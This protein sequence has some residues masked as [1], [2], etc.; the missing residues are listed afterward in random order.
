MLSDVPSS[1]VCRFALVLAVVC[2]ECAPVK[3]VMLV[4]TVKRALQQR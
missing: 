2:V 4:P 1:L 3:Q